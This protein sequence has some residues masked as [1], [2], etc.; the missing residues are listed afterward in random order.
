MSST[1]QQS[2]YR[3]RRQRAAAI[4]GAALLVL[5]AVLAWS[6]GGG[7][8]ALIDGDGFRPAYPRLHP[9]AFR[10][11]LRGDDGA[12]LVS[13]AGGGP[14]GWW[15]AAAAA[16]LLVWIILVVRP[17]VRRGRADPRRKV[18][19]SAQTAA[20]ELSLAQ[21]RKNGRYTRPHLTSRRGAGAEFGYYLG[22]LAGSKQDLWVDFE[23]RVRIIARPGWGKTSRLLVP[24]ARGV[25]GAALIGSVKADLFEQTVTARQQRGTV[26]VVDFSAP[27]DRIAEGFPEVTWNP[28]NGCE[29]LSVATRRAAALVAGSE[30]GNREDHDDAFWRQ[31]ARQVIEAWLHA[32]ALA[33][34]GISD[35]L[36][37]QENIR[38]PEPFDILR[39]HPAAEQRALLALTKH[40]DD[41]AERTTSSVERFIVLALGPFA[42]AIGQRFVGA[43]QDSLDIRRAI[44]EHETIYLL[45]SEDTAGAAAPVLTLFAEEWFYQARALAASKPG[46]RLAPPAVA[47]LDE[48]RWLV[49]L[50]S[51]PAIAS[52]DRAAGIGLIYALQT[53]RQEVELYG[54]SSESLESGAVQV[55]IFG[56]YDKSAAQTITSQAGPALVPTVSV[57]GSM[58]QGPHFT[59]SEQHQDALNAADQQQLRDGDSV[60]RVSGLPLAY[61]HTPSFRENRR[62]ARAIR[63][64]EQQVQQATAAARVHAAD[65]R[66]REYQQHTA[67]YQARTTRPEADDTSARGSEQSWF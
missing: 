18:L 12:Q 11:V 42:S 39:Q 21:V 35:V 34:L 5:G 15:I 8:A 64:E 57:G 20:K 48:L 28:I 26:R 43:P 63:Q 54:P 62:L 67:A 66:Q 16:I 50:P 19:L 46:G 9:E 33:G 14:R 13:I 1:E 27:A 30:D 3:T 38:S 17:L 55:S 25:P 4:G 59:D 29:D 58:L 60:L 2:T 22:R 61:M 36:R 44:A 53:M 32:A 47:V 51:L 7:L 45:A 56:G 23:K 40:L 31:S 6:V 10:G 52:R 49:P 37:W 24:I 41:R 65:Q